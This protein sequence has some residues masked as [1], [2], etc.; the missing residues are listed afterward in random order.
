M[1]QACGG[2]ARHPGG[3]MVGAGAAATASQVPRKHQAGDRREEVGRGTKV[4]G[5]Q[6][7]QEEI[8]N[9]G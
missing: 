4:G 2:R 1:G 6:D 5:R 9:A 7:L 3:G 8:Q